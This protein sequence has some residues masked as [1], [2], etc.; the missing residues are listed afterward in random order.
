MRRDDSHTPVLKVAI[1]LLMAGAA[2][3]ILSHHPAVAGPTAN[4]P[5]PAPP[6]TSPTIPPPAPANAPVAIEAFDCFAAEPDGAEVSGAPGLSTWKAGGPSGAAWN[7]AALLCRTSVRSG[8]DDGQ[9][10]TELRIGKAVVASATSTIR[11]HAVSWRFGL[12]RK[13]WEKH[14]DDATGAAGKRAPYRTAVF[15]L[16]A[17]LTCRAPYELAPGVG[18][19][20]EFAA[21]QMFV[22]GFAYGE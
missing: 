5:V 13:Q 6:R 12:K 17:T 4:A 7:V 19:R 18:P 21:D 1:A 15:R 10:L 2:A 3:A 22:A 16:T 11:Q 14:L 9:L 20:T 8:C